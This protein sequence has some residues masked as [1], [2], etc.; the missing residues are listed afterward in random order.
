MNKI[1]KLLRE[2]SKETSLLSFHIHDHPK[3]EEIIAIGRDAVPILLDHLRDF[4]KAQAN[5]YENCDFNDYAPWYAIIALS[6][7][8]QVNPIKPEHAG[9]LT[10][11]IQDWLAWSKN[12]DTLAEGG[13]NLSYWPLD[14]RPTESETDHQIVTD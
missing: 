11:I 7:I 14:N 5:N 1:T 9:R 10:D 12:P 2:I 4:L 13:G 6:R 8:T 3:L